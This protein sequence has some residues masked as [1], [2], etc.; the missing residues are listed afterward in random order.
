M[1]EKRM[2]LP[3]ALGES[4]PDWKYAQNIG[5]EIGDSEPPVAVGQIDGQSTFVPFG[6]SAVVVCVT[7]AVIIGVVLLW[8]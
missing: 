5:L 4:F 8:S 7:L 2:V 6:L 1:N 3:L